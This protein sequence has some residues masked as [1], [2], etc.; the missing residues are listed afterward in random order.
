MEIK[1]WNIFLKNKIWNMKYGKK[2]VARFV[3]HTLRDS[4]IIEIR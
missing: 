2:F 1:S 3:F 4:N